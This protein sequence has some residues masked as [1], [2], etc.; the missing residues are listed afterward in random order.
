MEGEGTSEME[1]TEIESSADYFDSSIL[2]NIIND[3]SAFVLY[4]HQQVPSI[5]Q[6]MSIEFDTLHE[7]YKELGSELAQ[8]ELKASSRRKHT[9]RMREVRQGIKRMEKLMNSV[10]GFQAAIKTLIS[11]TPNVQEVLLILGATP[12]RPQ[13]VYELCFSHKNV[14]VRGADYFVKHKAAEVLSRKQAIRT[15]ISKDAGSA[16]YPGPTKLF[17]LVKAPSSINLPLHFIPKR[18]FRY[19][20]KIKPFK[21]RFKCKAQIHQMNDPGLDREFQVGN[22][23]DLANSSVEDS[24]WFQCRHAI[25]GIAFNRPDED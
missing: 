3:V 13:Y 5:L 9:G 16:S 8:N 6:D 4:M 24:I 18:E 17:L 11:E 1:Y 19:S 25:K 23:D 2:F 7:E 14:V 22:S 12:L 10:S 21:L 20:K 15:L